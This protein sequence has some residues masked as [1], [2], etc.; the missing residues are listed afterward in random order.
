MVPPDSN[1]KTHDPTILP[2]ARLEIHSREIE[3]D[4]GN[5]ADRVGC[6]AWI[7]PPVRRGR[8][9]AV[10]AVRTAQIVRVLKGALTAPAMA[11]ILKLEISKRRICHCS[12]VPD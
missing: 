9:H 12:A 3:V 4:S 6:A 7:V 5:S 1:Q 10:R 11:W 8:I 2:F